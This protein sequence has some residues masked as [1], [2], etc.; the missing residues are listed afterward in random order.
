MSERALEKEV[1]IIES[2]S[3]KITI[4]ATPEFPKN[5]WFG[6]GQLNSKSKQVHELFFRYLSELKSR[7]FYQIFHYG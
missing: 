2:H 7:I 5:L 6:G 4:M 1:S 3:F